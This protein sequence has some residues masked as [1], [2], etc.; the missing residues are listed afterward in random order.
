LLPAGASA[1]LHEPHR[2]SRRLWR[3]TFSGT[4]DVIAYLFAHGKPIAYQHMRREWPIEA[5]QTIYASEAG[6]AEMPSAGRPF[7]R[8]MLDRLC[9]KGVGIASI[10]LHAGVSSPERDEPPYEEQ[11]RVPE[12]TASRVRRTRAR[13]GRVIAVGTTVVRALESAASGP[14]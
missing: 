2:S 13:G 5:Y 10:V 6:S 11:Y 8:E 4:G 9:A 12:E 1:I 3:A 7:T 14:R